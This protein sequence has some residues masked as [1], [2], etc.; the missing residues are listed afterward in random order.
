MGP[1]DEIQL[2]NRDKNNVTVKDIVRF[3]VDDK[4]DIETMQRAVSNSLQLLNQ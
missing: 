1:A 4:E 2:I 3:Y